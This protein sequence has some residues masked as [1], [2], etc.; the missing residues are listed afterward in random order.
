[1]RSYRF[2]TCESWQTQ[3][4]LITEVIAQDNT[5][6]RSHYLHQQ[7]CFTTSIQIVESYYSL[8]TINFFERT[9]QIITMQKFYWQNWCQHIFSPLA[10]KNVGIGSTGKYL[11]K[12]SNTKVRDQDVKLW[13]RVQM[14]VKTG[15]LPRGV[16]AV[17]VP[18]THCRFVAKLKGV[19]WHEWQ[20]LP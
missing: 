6:K 1:M 4:N 20:H 14:K 8:H 17:T 9:H 10:K 11:I 5:H 3:R 16:S 19:A 15:N 2:H 12:M 18:P 7:I 13:S